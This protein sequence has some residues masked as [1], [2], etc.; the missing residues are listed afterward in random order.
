MPKFHNNNN[1]YYVIMFSMIKY[2]Y[3]YIYFNILNCRIN[4]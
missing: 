1:D 2:I 4:K 3:K